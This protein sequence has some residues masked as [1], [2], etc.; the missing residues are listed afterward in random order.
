MLQV[1]N[2]GIISQT[3]SILNLVSGRLLL[4]MRVFGS[5]T[6]LISHGFQRFGQLVV[7]QGQLYC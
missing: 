7:A 4:N 1:R 6:L 2:L 3:S 5:F